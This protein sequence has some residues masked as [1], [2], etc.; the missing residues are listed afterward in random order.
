MLQVCVISQDL[1]GAS[2]GRELYDAVEAEL[3]GS[4]GGFVDVLVNNGWLANASSHPPG[5]PDT[6]PNDVARAIQTRRR[7]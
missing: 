3:R 1:S 2:S 5:Y 4:G 6:Q 7:S